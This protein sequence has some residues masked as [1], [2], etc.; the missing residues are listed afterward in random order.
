MQTKALPTDFTDTTY[1][2]DLPLLILLITRMIKRT[3][4]D[5]LIPVN[6]LHLQRVNQVASILVV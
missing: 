3:V 5:P 6:N 4:R 2:T 1:N